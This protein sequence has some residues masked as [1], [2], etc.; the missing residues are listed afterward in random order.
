MRWNGRMNMIPFD[1]YPD[2][3]R[4]L[5]GQVKGANC[6]HEYGLQF[7]QKTSQTKCAY[8]GA[9]FAES[10]DIWLTMTLD[11]VVPVS[12]CAA[13]GILAEW[14]EDITNKV[15]A[16]AACNSFRNR[17]KPPADVEC[18]KTLGAFYDLRDRIF[19]ERKK[20]IQERHES[21]KAFFNRLKYELNFF[22]SKY[23]EPS[24][25]AKERILSQ[26]KAEQDAGLLKPTQPD[27]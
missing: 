27:Q 15:L 12:V 26:L 10:Y 5:L 18:P 2:G 6:R 3:G 13:F 16:C 24:P 19:T 22:R 17:Y 1:E 11:H 8:C 21:E 4:V 23:P 25:E 7:M 20:A 14:Q 9:D